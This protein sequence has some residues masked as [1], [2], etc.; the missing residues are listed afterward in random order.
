MNIE[1]ISHA[2]TTGLVS[3]YGGNTKFEK[4]TRGSF[5]ISSSHFKKD[6][7]VYRD[8]WTNGGGQEIVSVEGEQFTRVYAGS[9]VE[10]SPEVIPHLIN[11][12]QILKDKTRLFSD[13][14]LTEGDWQYQYK[15]LD[16]EPNLNITVGKETIK[17]QNETVFVHC[18][19]LSPI[20]K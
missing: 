3:G 13:C 2:L 8:E 17:Y 16:T 6:G 7:I 1:K 10:N 5:E 20:K 15:I 12:I 19:V 4:T 11:F 14:E 9:A 18:F